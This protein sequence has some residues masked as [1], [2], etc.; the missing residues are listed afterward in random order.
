MMRSALGDSALG[1][2]NNHVCVLDRTEAV[3]HSDGGPP[4]LCF[5]QRHLNHAFRLD[6]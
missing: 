6:V 2:D 3:R 5:F 4:T 1:K